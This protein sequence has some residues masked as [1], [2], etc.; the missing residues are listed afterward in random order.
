MTFESEELMNR[1]DIARLLGKNVTIDVVRKNEKSL[2]LKPHKVK[3]N[4]RNI[5]YR[6]AGVM[7]T[8]GEL[9]F[10]KKAVYE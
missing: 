6:R 4:R 9:G 3:I 8:L 5:L 7:K 1:H 2:G 10:V